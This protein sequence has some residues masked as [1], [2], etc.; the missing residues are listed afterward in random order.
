MKDDHKQGELNLYVH[1]VYIYIYSIFVYGTY[2]EPNST[3]SF[4]WNLH[5]G[6]PGSL[7]TTASKDQ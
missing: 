7:T 6:S 1:C 4:F 3:N 5:K 2:A